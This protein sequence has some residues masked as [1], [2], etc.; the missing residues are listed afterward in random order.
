L[1]RGESKKVWRRALYV[2]AALALGGLGLVFSLRE[3]DWTVVAQTLR[4][5]RPM[6]LAWALLGTLGVVVVKAA[7]WYRLLSVERSMGDWW[8][9]LSILVLAQ[10][11]NIAVPV[12]GGGEALRVGLMA[13]R[14]PVK[15]LEVGGTV[16]VEKVADFLALGLIGLII[17]PS[18]AQ[19]VEK[20]AVLSL[21]W[22]AGLGGLLTI[23]VL[24]RIRGSLHKWLSRWPTARRLV[25][26]LLR[27]FGMVR[28][29]SS[30]W[31]LVVWTAAVWGLSS[32]SLYAVL[33]AT[34]VTPPLWGVLALILLLHASFVLPTAPGLVGVV[35]TVCILVLGFFGFS[36]GRA[37]GVSVVVHAVLV[38]P[39][40]VLALPAWLYVGRKLV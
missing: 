28:S 39:L 4:T 16:V 29:T 26:Q 12:R 21:L 5:I 9:S 19:M 37:L 27:G 15:M 36:R 10:A 18:A 14:F 17:V 6:W 30:V 22:L 23:V 35:Q 2:L 11:V 8:S 34:R 20:P 24:V 40:I 38:L 33:Q 3:V 25:D 31:E 13:R 32:G 7:R 1:N